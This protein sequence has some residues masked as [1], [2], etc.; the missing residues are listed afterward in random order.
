MLKDAR[1]KLREKFSMNDQVLL[2]PD[3][4]ER[5]LAVERDKWRAKGRAEYQAA[6]TAAAVER[7]ELDARLAAQQVLAGEAALPAASRQER[8]L[9]QLLDQTAEAEAESV[10][11]ERTP[12]QVLARYLAAQDEGPERAFVRVLER[13]Y[14]AQVLD[15]SAASDALSMAT[16]VRQAIDSRRR[17]RVRPDDAAR[18]ARLAALQVDLD[19]LAV[20][21]T[22]NSE[23]AVARTLGAAGKR[24]VLAPVP[25]RTTPDAQVMQ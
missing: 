16:R 14:L 3:A 1:A 8:L 22:P 25:R 15:L 20:R 10:I 21:I 2:A 24:G 7:V 17:A 5:F 11:D 12:D 4:E 13:R 19:K 9:A 23:R 18:A 6:V